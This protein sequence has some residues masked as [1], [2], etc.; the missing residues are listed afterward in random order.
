MQLLLAELPG[1]GLTVGIAVGGRNIVGAEVPEGSD[2]G[3]QLAIVVSG[4]FEW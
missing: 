4:A 1:R 3:V 2:P